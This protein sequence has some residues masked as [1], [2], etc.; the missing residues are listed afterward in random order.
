MSSSRIDKI[1]GWFGLPL[2]VLLLV[3]VVA[4]IAN[5]APADTLA[6]MRD[7]IFLRALWLSARTTTVSVL[8]V[9][10][11]GTPLAWW[12]ARSRARY[13]SLVEAL[14]HAPIV[15]PPAVIGLGLLH[16][17]SRTSLLGGALNAAGL[18]IVFTTTAVIVAQTVVAAP[19][20]VQAAAA[21]FRRIDSDLVLVARSL[22]HGPWSVFRSVV[23][24]TAR[25]GIL[26]GLA[27]AW[28]RALG[29]FG[30]TLLFAGNLTGSTQT[31]PLAIFAALESDVRVATALALVLC[32]ASIAV[33]VL[34]RNLRPISVRMT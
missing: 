22:G 12:L 16:A 1:A 27:L 15:L 3:P 34:V 19:F 7:P 26:G 14:V 13:A 2:L 28:A 6:A 24:P 10:V 31:A 4:L 8:I 17:F 9:A 32:A 29:E 25:A 18:Q 23:L 21:S 11:L 20:Y 30:A 33:L 5:S